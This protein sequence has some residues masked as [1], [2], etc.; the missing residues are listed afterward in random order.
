MDHPAVE[1]LEPAL[2]TL[3]G[4]SARDL[5]TERAPTGVASRSERASAAEPSSELLGPSAARRRE[6]R[7]ENL[8]YAALAICM[9]VSNGWFALSV[10]KFT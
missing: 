3:S 1:Q 9:A 5:A 6:G 10:T 8:N 7:I 2:R 4:S